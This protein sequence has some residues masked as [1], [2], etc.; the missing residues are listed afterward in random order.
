MLR[1]QGKGSGGCECCAEDTGSGE[2]ETCSEEECGGGVSVVLKIRAQE[3][4]RHFL[5]KS[6]VEG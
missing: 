4:L 6:V 2:G 5:K 3:R 1:L